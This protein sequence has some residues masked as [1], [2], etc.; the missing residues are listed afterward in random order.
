VFQGL[1]GLFSFVMV[2]ALVGCSAKPD[3]RNSID[4]GVKFLVESQQPDGSWGTGTKVTRGNEIY[5]MVPGSHDAYRVATTALCVMALREVGETSAHAKGVEY[6]IQSGD[7]RRDSG[8]LLYNVWAHIY[9]LQALAVEMRNNPD[10]RIKLAAQK[11]L[12]R[13]IQYTVYTGG[14]NYYDF[15]SQTQTPSMG[16]TSFNTAAGLVA[17]DEARKAGLDVPQRLI[18]TALRRLI[19]CRTPEGVYLYGFDYRYSPRL[20]ANQVKG[21]IGRTQPANYALWLWNSDQVGET[22]ALQGL[23]LFFQNHHF[24]E[25]GRKRPFPHEAWYQTSGYYYY[26]DHYYAGLLVERLNPAVKS[27]YSRDLAKVIIPHQEAD[28]SWWDYP[29]WD[30]DK[31]YGTA[32]AVMTLRR[33]S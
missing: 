32:F 14:W 31:P 16:A 29:M 10:P 30:Y 26:F 33:C 8:D 21:A 27:R 2:V 6:L 19:Q 18:D 1:R 28:G 3:Y 20:P 22:Q 7:A 13:L 4:R 15:N 24:L 12:N 11:Q 25:I 17:L 9:A 5:S 23:D